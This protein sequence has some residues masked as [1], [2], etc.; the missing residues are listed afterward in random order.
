MM[1]FEYEQNFKNSLNHYFVEST[2]NNLA[3]LFLALVNYAGESKKLPKISIPKM[4][5]LSYDL[6]NGDLKLAY[7]ELKS[8]PSAKSVENMILV[9]LMLFKGFGLTY[10]EFRQ[11]LEKTLINKLDIM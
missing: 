9:I 2:P 8:F 7:M 4:Y 3:V 10:E 5:E 11:K 1:I 6:D